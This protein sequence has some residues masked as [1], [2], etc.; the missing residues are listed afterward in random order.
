[1]A[2]KNVTSNT[3]HNV[4]PNGPNQQQMPSG[5]GPVSAP[6]VRAAKKQLLQ[7]LSQ[8]LL[9]TSW[10]SG[11]TQ[12]FP[13]PTNG[14]LKRIWLTVTGSGGAKGGTV[15]VAGGA[16]APFNIF[17]SMILSDANGTPIWNLSSYSAQLARLLGGYENFR[18]DQSTY[19]F[20]PIDGTAG[21]GS[22]TGNFKIK[23]EIPI[24]FGQ[25]G[26]GCLP[27]MDSSA[28]YHLDVAYN[29][30]AN[31]Y[32]GSAQQ[33]AT[34]PNITTL[35]EL[36]YRAN[37]TST[38]MYG[39]AQD[40]VPPANGTVAYWTR[41]IFNVVS[42]QNVI[43][44]NRVG[45]IIRNH[46]LIFRD[47]NGSR[48]VADSSGVTPSVI[49]MDWDATIRYKANVDTLREMNYEALGFDVPAGVILLPNTTDPTGFTGHEDGN[50][51]LPT[52]GSTLLQFQFTNSA[53]G[54]LEVVTNDIVAASGA[55]WAAPLKQ[56]S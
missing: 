48:S 24:E 34:L 26:L 51:W 28:Q 2:L 38:D 23:I 40:T 44:L 21:G 22:G 11:F 46:I 4:Q 56:I 41:Q 3:V 43:Q 42:G 45:N 17:S 1:M 6:F 27:N 16:D 13:V 39:A 47:A 37:P 54:T 32:N 18:N 50:Q 20:T 30:P 53:V 5:G 25:D 15:T 29:S 33:P 7:G 19:G 8:T 36:E 12:T 35:I 55:I 31:F 9:G 14:W 49:E 10:V 52:V